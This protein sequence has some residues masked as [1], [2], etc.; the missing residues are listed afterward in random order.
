LRP[1]TESIWEAF[2]ERLRNF[3]Q[4]R[5]SDADDVEDLL[6]ETFIRIHTRIDTLVDDTRLAAWVYQIARNL[7][8]DYYRRRIESMPLTEVLPAAPVFEDA[9]AEAEI[10]AGLKDMVQELPEKYRQAIWLTE[11]SGL[12]QTELA[13]Q[14]GLSPSGAKSRVQRG[15]EMLRQSLL[16]CCHFEFDRL[17]GMIAYTRRPDC[18]Q[19]CGC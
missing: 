8:V 14:L 9:S 7:I 10:A 6:Q 3:I 15:R 1:T 16:E 4:S 13:E 17:G 11:F 19:V 18:C 5:V 2:S 12:K